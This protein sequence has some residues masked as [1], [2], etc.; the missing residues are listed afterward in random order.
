MGLTATAVGAR[1]QMDEWD[2]KLCLKSTGGPLVTLTAVP[3]ILALRSFLCRQGILPWLTCTNP[4]DPLEFDD[5]VAFGFVIAAVVNF[6][7]L[8]PSK[9][10][11]N[12]QMFDA[13][14]TLFGRSGCIQI[15]LWGCAY[16]AAARRYATVPWSLV[17]FALGKAYYVVGAFTLLQ[18]N[19]GS[20][21]W[22]CKALAR[23][24]EIAHPKRVQPA[25]FGLVESGF[26]LFF[27][28]AAYVAFFNCVPTNVPVCK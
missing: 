27:I 21:H 8:I 23:H 3:L 7:I 17:V 20:R 19:A 1:D 25:G 24:F 26:C 14:P 10:L 11:T 12:Q 9:L 16:L 18:V 28:W 22:C 13:W 15:L 2:G 4:L 5:P 6:M